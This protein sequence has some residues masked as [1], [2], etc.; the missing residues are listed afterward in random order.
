[1]FRRM[2]LSVPI[3]LVMGAS[4]VADTRDVKHETPVV[5]SKAGAH[6]TDD[7]NCFNRYH[8]AIKPCGPRKAGSGHHHR[9]A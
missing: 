8:P 1:M 9:D 7:P 3:L 4:A 5:V 6:C 2:F